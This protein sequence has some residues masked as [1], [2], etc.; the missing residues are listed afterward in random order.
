MADTRPQLVHPSVENR[1]QLVHP[2]AE[3]RPPLVHPL[4]EPE[5]VEEGGIPGF[6]ADRWE[7]LK[8][9]AGEEIQRQLYGASFL[10]PE[11]QEQARRAKLR[12]RVEPPRS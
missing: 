10:L 5:V 12:D 11:A 1:P 3:N 4:V 7:D 9:G 2:S 8:A 6:V